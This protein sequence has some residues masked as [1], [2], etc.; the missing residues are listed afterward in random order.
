[1]KREDYLRREIGYG[2]FERRLTLPEGNTTEN[3][4]ATFKNAVLEIAIPLAK[5][6]VATKVP[7]E[8]KEEKEIELENK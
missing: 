3:L 7:I 5:E 8:S 4:I 6:T 2:L 1:V